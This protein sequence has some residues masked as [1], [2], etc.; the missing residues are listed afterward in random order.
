MTV[1]LPSNFLANARG[2]TLLDGGGVTWS[3]NKNTNEISAVASSSGG[4]LTGV[5]SSNLTVAGTATVPTISLSTG[6]VTNIAAGG[7]ALQL[8]SV[9]APITGAGTPASK[10]GLDLTAGYAWV[11]NHTFSPVSGVAQTLNGVAGQI[12]LIINSGNV[13]TAAVADLRVNRAGS[14]ANAAE[15]GPNVLLFDSTNSRGSLLQNS[16]GQFELWQF[17]GSTFVQALVM[18]VTAQLS[19]P[20][21]TVTTSA[22]AGAAS[23]LPG[24]PVGYMQVTIAG[25]AR[26][27]PFWT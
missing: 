23:A 5:G 2:F 8:V 21:A 7:T 17:N 24:A 22:I 12:S 27:I 9:N 11:G 26:K 13:A 20:Q 6:Q 16:G 1:K 18:S 10:L 4:T 19:L 14:T 25:T 3:I 15:E